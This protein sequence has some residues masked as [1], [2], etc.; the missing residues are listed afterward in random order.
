MTGG[1]APDLRLR[2]ATGYHAAMITMLHSSS[3]LL[4]TVLTVIL[5]VPALAQVQNTAIVTVDSG[6]DKGKYVVQVPPQKAPGG[7]CEIRKRADGQPGVTFYGSFYP[8]A[9][10]RSPKTTPGAPMETSLNFSVPPGG[11]TDEV[12]LSVL[13]AVKTELLGL[14][15]YEIETRRSPALGVK[16]SG[17]ATAT[18]ARSGSTAT[19]KIEAET[20]DKVRVTIE[21]DCRQ[22]IEK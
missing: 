7:T 8:D 21:I 11:T 16:Q 18:L 22:V 3:R 2:P 9:G 6:P 19:A 15:A 13:F 4:P 1:T 12:N 20:K 14:R 10:G 5:V 17:R